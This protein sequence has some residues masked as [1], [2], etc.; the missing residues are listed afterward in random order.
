[1]QETKRAFED[2]CPVAAVIPDCSRSAGPG[3]PPSRRAKAPLRRDGG[4]PGSLMRSEV[5]TRIR[6]CGPGG[7]D[8]AS[9]GRQDACRYRFAGGAP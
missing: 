2:T 5:M 9:Y 1:M 7:R 6:F 8:A 4:Q 3:F